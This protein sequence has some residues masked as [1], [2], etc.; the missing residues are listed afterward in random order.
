MMSGFF[1]SFRTSGRLTG[2][3]TVNHLYFIFFPQG[4]LC[5][6]WTRW[7]MWKTDAILVSITPC[8]NK[9]GPFQTPNQRKGPNQKK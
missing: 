4:N 5:L 7:C 6:L 8:V 3:Q 1:C 2:N 9:E